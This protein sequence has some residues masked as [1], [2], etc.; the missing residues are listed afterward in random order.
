MKVFISLTATACNLQ[1]SFILTF[2]API[3]SLV[4]YDDQMSSFFMIPFG[5]VYVDNQFYKGVENADAIIN[6]FFAKPPKNIE[7][8]GNFFTGFSV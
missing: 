7:A 1:Q 3:H 6:D 5:D 2:R 8:Y 4:G